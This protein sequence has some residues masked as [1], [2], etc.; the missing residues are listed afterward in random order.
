MLEQGQVVELKTGF[1]LLEGSQT[2]QGLHDGFQ[3]WLSFSGAGGFG[4]PVGNGFVKISHSTE[5]AVKDD[6]CESYHAA[7]R[8]LIE[9][10]VRNFPHGTFLFTRLDNVFVV[11]FR[12]AFTYYPEG[13]P[14][15]CEQLLTV[16]SVALWFPLRRLHL[17]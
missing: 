3:M 2:E 15:V 8:R 13:M 1:V 5:Y 4:V 12:N 16:L 14:D 7:A 9:Q 17:P 11:H 10:Q 6:S